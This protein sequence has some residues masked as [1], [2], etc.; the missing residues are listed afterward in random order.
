MEPVNQDTSDSTANTKATGSERTIGAFS[1]LAT[2][3]SAVVTTVSSTP[4]VGL[5]PVVTPAPIL[6]P[7]PVIATPPIASTAPSVHRPDREYEGEF[8]PYLE[9]FSGIVNQEIQEVRSL[10]FACF[11]GAF[12][13]PFASFA[14]GA[15][16][17]LLQHQIFHIGPFGFAQGW[18][19]ILPW[20]AAVAAFVRGAHVGRVVSLSGLFTG[21]ARTCVSKDF[22][23]N[24]RMHLQNVL[25][26]IQ[27]HDKHGL[28]TGRRE[29]LNDWIE[30]LQPLDAFNRCLWTC[31]LLL[32]IAV[33]AELLIAVA[34]F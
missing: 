4:A 21:R 10:A 19:V 33:L 5:T 26:A 28:E 3:P 2:G 27:A 30:A 12:L 23:G 16:I 8:L 31:L 9:M 14:D 29:L 24:I 25:N 34:P 18:F 7:I 13:V 22:A 17:A 32:A 15:M 20:M 6:A 11:T 1:E